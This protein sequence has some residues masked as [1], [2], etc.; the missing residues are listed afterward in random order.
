MHPCNQ[1]M[2]RWSTSAFGEKPGPSQ[3]ELAELAKHVKQCR[4]AR[5]PMYFLRSTMKTTSEI[6]ASR[7]W[8]T[9]AVVAL[10][11]LLVS[12]MSAI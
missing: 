6:I 2:A 7:L 10:A 11:L 1:P 4:S 5:G 9:V 12:V 8:T 3:Q